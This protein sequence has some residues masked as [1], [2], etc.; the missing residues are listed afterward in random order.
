MYLYAYVNSEVK[1][2]HLATNRKDSKR[3]L[4]VRYHVYVECRCSD[5]HNR[6]ASYFLIEQIKLAIG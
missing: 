6:I 4:V 2:A 5:R 1:F 3:Q